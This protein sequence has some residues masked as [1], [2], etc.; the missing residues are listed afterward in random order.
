MKK[1]LLLVI[2]LSFFITACGNN[3]NESTDN[4]AGMSVT[5]GT[6]HENTKICWGFRKIK[7]A[8]PE[9][10]QSTAELL[11]RY[12]SYYIGD[13]SKKEL[14]LTFD[15]GYENGYTP[16]IL[17]VLKETGVP[18]AFFV[19][20]QFITEQPQLVKRMTDE[21][22]IVGNHS[23]HHPSFPDTDDEKLKQEITGLNEM[24]YKLTG[25]NMTYLRPPKGE[26]SE[27]T[28]AISK[29]LG[30]KNIFW[31]SA[32]VDWDVN[33]RIGAQSAAE[34]VTSQYHNGNIILLHAV[35]KDNAD[36]LKTM[37]NQAKNEGYTFKSLDNL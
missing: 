3:K 11:K 20:G 16:Q 19:T 17:D 15:E 2:F 10:P 21:G 32:Y 6:A 4:N 33:K 35:S 34:K 14:Y 22:H 24:Y 28:L 29:E 25:K 18:A 30:Y 9:V 31:S 26:F 23:V 27:R 8:A 13:Q 12:D 37:I 1:I 5:A 7:N 36:G